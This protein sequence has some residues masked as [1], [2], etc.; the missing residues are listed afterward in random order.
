MAKEIDL[1]RAQPRGRQTA[2]A[3]SPLG[4]AKDVEIKLEMPPLSGQALIQRREF[5]MGKEY[6]P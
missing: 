4:S 1:F 5:T 3:F 2:P 6:P